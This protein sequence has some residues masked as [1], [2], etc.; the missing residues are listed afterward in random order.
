[1]NEQ[2]HQRNLAIH[3]HTLALKKPHLIIIDRYHLDMYDRLKHIAPTICLDYDLDWKVT[4]RKLA[5]ILGR[6]NK[7][8]HVINQLEASVHQSRRKIRSTLGDGSLS[9]IRITPDAIRIVGSPEHPLNDLL[10]TELDVSAGSMTPA[11]TSKIELS[12]D[13]LSSFSMQSDFLFIQNRF[14]GANGADIMTRVH[15]SP[16]WM[17]HEAVRHNRIRFIPNWYAMSWTPLGRQQIIET[18]SGIEGCQS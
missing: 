8:E 16:F 6:E 10:F 13:Q 11:I 5:E 17:Q 12:P 18:L 1:M 2:E 14:F 15:S 7:A 4:Y 3:F 9:L